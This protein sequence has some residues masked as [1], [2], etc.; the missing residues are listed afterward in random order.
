MAQKSTEELAITEPQE[1]IHGVLECLQAFGRGL[2]EHPA[3]QTQIAAIF[4]EGRENFWAGW[5]RTFRGWRNVGRHA[6]SLPGPPILLRPLV[7]FS[8]RAG[9]V[10]DWRGL[11]P[12]SRSRS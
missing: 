4:A 2:G 3:D 1:R 5:R 11:P 7:V 6:A 8:W 10:S 12:S 9:S